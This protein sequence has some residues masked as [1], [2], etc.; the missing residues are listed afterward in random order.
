[1]LFCSESSFVINIYIYIYIWSFY[2]SFHQNKLR[3]AQEIVSNYGTNLI[4]NDFSHNFIIFGINVNSFYVL[5]F[6]VFIHS[7][8]KVVGYKGGAMI[9]Y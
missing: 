8:N 5:F 7:Q 4:V 1:M 9:I 3:I 6:K 2:K